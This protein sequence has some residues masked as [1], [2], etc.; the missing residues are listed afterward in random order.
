MAVIQE[1]MLV[2]KKM[3]IRRPLQSQPWVIIVYLPG[4]GQINTMCG[5]TITKASQILITT[6]GIFFAY[7]KLNILK[8]K[9]LFS[10]HGLTIGQ[11]LLA[12]K[13]KTQEI[14]SLII[15]SMD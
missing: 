2:V 1:L 15:I 12:A 3:V 5:T 13:Q 14:C 4:P 7:L 9:R 11:S 8:R 6:I 10:Q